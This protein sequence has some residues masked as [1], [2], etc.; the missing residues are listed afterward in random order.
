MTSRKLKNSEVS[1]L[2]NPLRVVNEGVPVVLPVAVDLLVTGA[3]LVVDG[4]GRVPVAHVVLHPQVH[5]PLVVASAITASPVLVVGNGQVEVGA[6]KFSLQVVGELEAFTRVVCAS[7]DLGAVSTDVGL[8]AGLDI[9]KGQ[10]ASEAIDVAVRG[11]KLKQIGLR[12]ITS[13]ETTEPRLG[14]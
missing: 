2:V 8:G 11:P 1:D 14:P 3:F 12:A 10:V 5:V 6:R 13:T 9:A 7:A 4:V